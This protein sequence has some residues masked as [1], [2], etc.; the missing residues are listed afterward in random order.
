MTRFESPVAVPPRVST[1]KN[2]S[3]RNSFVRSTYPA[4]RAPEE[5]IAE[6]NFG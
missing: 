6:V 2:Y 5:V 3:S 1:G 4:Q